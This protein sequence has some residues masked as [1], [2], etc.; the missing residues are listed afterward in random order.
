MRHH[1]RLRRDI[2]KDQFKDRACLVM[3]QGDTPFQVEVLLCIAAQ[4]NQFCTSK[5]GIRRR[6]DTAVARIAWVGGEGETLWQ[7]GTSRC[8][9]DERPRWRREEGSA[10]TPEIILELEGSARKLHAL[11]PLFTS[12]GRRVCYCHA[13]WLPIDS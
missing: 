2:A 3:Q 8:R 12:P 7:D 11:S 1:H 4:Y 5:V 10:S 6:D 13:V 9:Q